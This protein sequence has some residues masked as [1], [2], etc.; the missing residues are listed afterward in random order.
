MKI[1]ITYSEQERAAFERI[2]AE[3][4]QSLPNVR[5]HSSIAPN[6]VKALYLTTCKNRR[7]MYIYKI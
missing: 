7:F 3:L 6:G 2:R 1:K 5:Q 4:L